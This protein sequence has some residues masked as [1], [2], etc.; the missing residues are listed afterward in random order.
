MTDMDTFSPYNTFYLLF[1]L[2]NKLSSPNFKTSSFDSLT[3]IFEEARKSAKHLK[4][5]IT[6]SQASAILKKKNQSPRNLF[7]STA[8]AGTCLDFEWSL[9]DCTDVSV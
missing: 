8:L 7:R 4:D 5:F 2:K 1:T 9:I 3:I 6:K